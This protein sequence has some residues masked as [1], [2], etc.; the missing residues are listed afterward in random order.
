MIER[1]P[2]PTDRIIA[3]T[4]PSAVGSMKTNDL[5]LLYV[6]DGTTVLKF[7]R[8]SDPW[9][10]RTR[11]RAML[12]LWNQHGINV[13]KLRAL[14]LPRVSRPYLAMSFVPGPSLRERLRGK[15]GA[16]VEKLALLDRV[17]REMRRRHELAIEAKEPRLIHPDCNTGNVILSENRVVWI[18]L[19][20]EGRFADVIDGA[21]A[22]ICK[23]TRWVVRDLS[24]DSLARVCEVLCG[25]Y[26]GLE[27]LLEYAR[28]RTC[29][30]PLQ[31]L[32]R[33]RNRRR[34]LVAPAQVTT[35]DVVDGVDRTLSRAGWRHGLVSRAA[36]RSRIEAVV[37]AHRTR[38]GLATPPVIAGL[39]IHRE[40]SISD[41]AAQTKAPS[42]CG[43]DNSID[44]ETASRRRAA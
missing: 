14:T 6:A 23:F 25:A 44:G 5:Y 8:G 10:R 36:L 27:V 18:D 15:D 4:G 3:D 30:R 16:E 9:R 33:W 41:T 40:P 22:E 20:C 21:A 19:E 13:P 38:T 37:S 26:C 32:H 17:Y 42:P 31:F 1:E 2:L 24:I 12:E 35:Y 29:C 39:R 28:H 7:Y 11:E 34:K 43:H